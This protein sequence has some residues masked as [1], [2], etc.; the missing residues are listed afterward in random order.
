MTRFIRKFVEAKSN[1][2]AI[3]KIDGAISSSLIA[4]TS[5]KGIFLY[6]VLILKK[7]RKKKSRP[8]INIK[9]MGI[10]K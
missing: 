6:D 4:K 5:K 2:D 1:S 9:S 10:L 7:Q 3:K 8:L